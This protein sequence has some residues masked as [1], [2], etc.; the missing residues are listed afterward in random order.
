MKLLFMNRNF[1]DRTL[2]LDLSDKVE[3]NSMPS[4][5][6]NHSAAFG[7]RCKYITIYYFFKGL[8]EIPD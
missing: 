1:R 8:V 7:I 4:F 5:S 6:K 2:Q 3:G